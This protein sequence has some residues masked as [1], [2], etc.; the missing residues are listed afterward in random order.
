[1]LIAILC[2][3]TTKSQIKA[4]ISSG[5]FSF[6]NKPHTVAGM[7]MSSMVSLSVLLTFVGLTEARKFIID[8]N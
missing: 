4:I 2:V 3:E 7:Q 1:M 8:L 6:S 5:S